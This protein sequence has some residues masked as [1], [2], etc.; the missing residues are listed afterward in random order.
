M[1]TSMAFVASFVVALTVTACGSNMSCQSGPKGTQCYGPGQQTTG[2]LDPTVN[3]VAPM[4]PTPQ[5]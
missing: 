2:K 3:N 1:R 5:R 4:P